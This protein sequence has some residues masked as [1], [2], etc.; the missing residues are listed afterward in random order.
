MASDPTLSDILKLSARTST[1]MSID[2]IGSTTLKQGEVE[3]DIV[4]TFLAYHKQVT[5]AAYQHH[6]EVI[7]ISGDG[8]MAR[9]Q[10]ADDAVAM[11]DTL[12]K[13]LPVFNKKQNRLGREF[14]LRVGI[15][16]GEVLEHESQQAGHLISQTLDIAAKLQQAASPN[17]ALISEVTAGQIPDAEKRFRRIGWNAALQINMFELGI[18]A[19]QQQKLRQMPRPARVLI[20]ES[21]PDEQAAL[22][23]ALFGSQYVT[24]S[25]YNQDEAVV[26]LTAWGP[27][28]VLASV[29]LPWDAGW[30]FLREMR[31]KPEFSVVPVIAASRQTTSEPIQR[32]FR[33]GA[34]GYL[35]KPFD[36]TQVAKRIELVLREFYL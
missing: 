22:R 31:S 6:G 9:F 17:R 24:F 12:L 5:D 35:K 13:S 21:E 14:Q 18:G 27:H 1:F 36:A 23:K 10:K 16:T 15:H 32:S 26:P 20:I 28:A 33:L 7:H 25:V 29:D 8:V 11:A 34:N 30:N 19:T 3:Q 4:Y 2:V